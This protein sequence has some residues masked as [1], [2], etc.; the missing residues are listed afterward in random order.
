MVSDFPAAQ[1]KERELD[2]INN[3]TYWTDAI[4]RELS[5]I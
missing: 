2:K 1:K 4:N 3:D 5:A